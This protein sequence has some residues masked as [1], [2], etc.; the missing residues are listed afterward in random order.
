MGRVA[1]DRAQKYDDGSNQN[2]RFYKIERITS[3]WT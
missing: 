3:Y 2:Y 1:P